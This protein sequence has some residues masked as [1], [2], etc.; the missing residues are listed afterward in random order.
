MKNLAVV[1]KMF[2]RGRQ[3]F[4]GWKPVLD[5]DIEAMSIQNDGGVIINLDAH[6]VNLGGS[7]IFQL[8]ISKEEIS[9]IFYNT[10]KNDSIGSLVENLSFY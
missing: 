1:M 7:Y 5:D 9:R 2:A 6:A 8:Q 4:M 3:R 10:H